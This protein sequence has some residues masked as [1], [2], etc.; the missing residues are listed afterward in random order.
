MKVMR[1]W[2]KSSIFF[3]FVGV[4]GLAEA[5]EVG[6]D[7]AEVITELVFDLFEDVGVGEVAMEEE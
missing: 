1:S 4:G 2:T 5:A 7:Y 6:G 3:D